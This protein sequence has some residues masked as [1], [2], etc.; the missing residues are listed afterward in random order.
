M[1]IF[2]RVGIDYTHTTIR[3]NVHEQSSGKIHEKKFG[4][5]SYQVIDLI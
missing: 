1:V 2:E 4:G 3:P 5:F